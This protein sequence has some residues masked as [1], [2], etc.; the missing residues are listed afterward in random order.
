MAG[1]SFGSI[2]RL[3]TFGESHGPVIGG[4]IDGC[5]SNITIDI[6]RIQKELDR[7]KPGA[8]NLVST[9]KEDDIIEILSG[10]YEGKSLGTPIAFVIRNK[11]SR[12]EDYDHLKNTFRPS[13]ADYTYHIKYGIRDHRGGGRSSARETAAR[14]AAG[15]IARILL[16]ESGM[17]VIACTSAIGKIKTDLTHTILDRK[18]IESN[19]LRCPDNEVYHE[20]SSYLDSVRREGDSTGSEVFCKIQDVLPGLGEPVF[21]KI[22][23]DLAKAML[24]INGANGF[25]IGSGFKGISMKG[26][27]HNDVFSGEPIPENDKS[28]TPKFLSNNAGGV[29]GGITNGQDIYFRVSFKPVPSIGIS[30]QTIDK[31]GHPVT[32]S[33]RGRH[34]STIAP[35]AVAVVEAMA[36]LVLTDHL[37]RYRMY[38]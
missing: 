23:A 37:L 30:Q 14:V 2:F 27:E 28:S 11:D 7:R 21:D 5:P 8:S 29:N 20:M 19:P 10:I 24:S 36:C 26:S 4:V 15:A 12:P 9:R 31:E 17:Q 1:N 3:T 16:E 33:G 13:H 18:I 22:Q 32:I 35:R 6:S 25:E 34:D 38:K